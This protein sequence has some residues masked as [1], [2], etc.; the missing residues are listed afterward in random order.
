M[1]SLN[2]RKLLNKS[3]LSALVISLLPA[4]SSLAA[5]SW[6]GLIGVDYQPNHYPTNNAFNFHNVFYVGMNSKKQAVTNVYAE[7]SQLKAAGF[8][9]V[10][11]YQTTDY[12]WIDIINQ[13]HTLGMKVVYEAVIP[14]NGS[15]A[16]INAAT[17]LLNTVITN[18]G[19][20]TF[21]S[22]VTLVLA[23]H[24]N[25]CDTCGPGGGSNIAY[26]T[27]AVSALQTVVPTI[28]VSSAL[29]SGDLVAPPS[30]DIT[31]LVN[32]YSPTAPLGFD[33]YPFQWGVPV[34][35]SVETVSSGST[36]NSIGWDYYQVSQQSYYVPPRPVLMAESGWASAGTTNPGYA[37]GN[38]CKPSIANEATYLTDLYKFVRV[39]GNN[40]GLLVF[41]A[42]D[43]PAKVPGGTSMENY[44]G[45]F[46]SNCNLK[47]PNNT[48]LLPNTR[49]SPT[50]NHGCQ[51]YS[52]GALMTI[53]GFG[54]PYTLIIS[55]KNPVTK[56]D[57]SIQLKSNGI[58]GPLADAPWPEYLVF[59]GATITIRG[60]PSCTSKIASINSAQQITFSGSCNCT[61][62]N[63]NN[64]YY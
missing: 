7:L 40:S 9:T 60:N 4:T 21:N 46:D 49:Y 23:G 1:K 38:N 56:E 8:N 36:L 55:Q 48:A 58:A 2:A 20:S 14:Q 30:S 6:R 43:E 28:P 13:A 39:P 32:S 15:T 22:T 51:G 10:R 47:G 29:V 3:V 24:E 31:T 41:E 63:L 11:S 17:A 53:V 59:P 33:P 54:H 64:C 34:A 37:C 61:N 25:Y 62:D 16:D 50:A 35:Q 27:Q 57:A 26:L 12:S 42:Y 18:V 52:K 19:Q 44:Y 45:M 5:T